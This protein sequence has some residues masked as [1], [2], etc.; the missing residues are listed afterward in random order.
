MRISRTFRSL[1]KDDGAAPALGAMVCPGGCEAVSRPLRRLHGHDRGVVSVFFLLMF[2]TFFNAAALVWNTGQT[3]GPRLKAQ[4]A[5]DVAAY[6]TSV[7]M[8]RAVNL[9]AMTNY[10]AVRNASAYACAWSSISVDIGVPINWAIWI[11]QMAEEA[12]AATGGIPIVSEAAAAAAALAATLYIIAVE[13]PPYLDFLF[14]TM[15][16]WGIAFDFNGG[17]CGRVSDLAEFQ[18]AIIQATPGVIEAQRKITEESF[19]GVSIRLSQPIT[20][21]DSD[22]DVDEDTGGNTGLVSAPLTEGNLLSAAPWFNMRYLAVDSGWPRSSTLREIV[23]GRAV[24]CWYIGGVPTIEAM[25]LIPG[26]KLH[27]LPTQWGP[28][29]FAAD[30]TESRK[31]FSVVASATETSDSKRQLFL[32]YWF[33]QPITTAGKVTAY[34]EAETYLGLDSSISTGAYS[35]PIPWRAWTPPGANWA[36]RLSRADHFGAAFEG[37]STMRTIYGQTQ[38]RQED[39]NGRIPKIILH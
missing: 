38:L 33:R 17:V 25:A 19:G 32:N 13:L 24:M 34:A 28:L 15:D 3:M 12:F 2:F 37:D 39:V 27:V 14:A 7:I 23:H 30:D 21:D 26:A 35:P 29:E 4:A 22:V 5:A 16:C 20:S 6:N 36:G 18:K 10:A 11:A 8:S 9:T 31:P 1:V